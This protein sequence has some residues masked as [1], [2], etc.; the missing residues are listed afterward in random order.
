[1][2]KIVIVAYRPR[3]GM[4]MQLVELV[5]DH[6]PI[7]RSEGLVTARQ[8]LVMRAADGTIIEIFEWKSA[9]AI[10]QAHHNKTVL[11]MWERFAEACDYESLANLPECRQPFSPFDPI[12]F[13]S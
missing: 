1:M 2:G 12:E 5:K 9:E 8:P 10:A 4:E 6:V 7:L 11:A 3:A 13:S